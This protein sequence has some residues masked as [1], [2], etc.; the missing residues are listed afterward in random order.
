M[1]KKWQKTNKTNQWGTTNKTRKQ[2]ILLGGRNKYTKPKHASH[3]KPKH[4]CRQMHYNELK[5]MFVVTDYTN[6]QV[7]GDFYI[8]DKTIDK[9]VK[10]YNRVNEYADFYNGVVSLYVG[11]NIGI[12]PGNVSALFEKQN[13]IFNMNDYG[14]KRWDEIC[15]TNFSA[16]LVR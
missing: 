15:V 3:S 5:D 11:N 16:I 14:K 9:I 12:K 13:G 8:L 7:I 1:A 6:N 2:H 4:D 10:I